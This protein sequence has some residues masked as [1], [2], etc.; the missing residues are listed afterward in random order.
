MENQ[1]QDYKLQK[2]RVTIMFGTYRLKPHIIG[3]SRSPNC[4]RRFD[5]PINYNNSE[6]AWKYLGAGFIHNAL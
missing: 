6:N 2:K 3:K 1:H 4:F 5:K